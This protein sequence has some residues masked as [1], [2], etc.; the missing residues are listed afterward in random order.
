MTPP[1]QPLPFQPLPTLPARQPAMPNAHPPHPASFPPQAVFSHAGRDATDAFTIWHPGSAWK[2]LERFY[3]GELDGPALEADASEADQALLKDFRAL[4]AQFK[5]EGLFKSN[6]LFYAWKVLSTFALCV[7][8]AA[9]AAMY[10]R[11]MSWAAYALSMCTMGVF[12]QQSGWLA[13]DFLHGQVFESRDLNE[14]FGYVIGNV[15]QGFSVAWW[16]NKH[17]YHHAACNEIE[18]DGTACDPDID[19]IPLLAWDERM[20]SQLDNESALQKWVIKNQAALFFPMLSFAK[21]TWNLSSWADVHLAKE[22]SS[23]HYAVEVA[24][25]A[26]HYL[27]TAALCVYSFGVSPA[28]LGY[29]I[30]ANVV[31]GSLVAFVFVQSHNGKEVH[32]YADVSKNWI[33]MQVETTRN[34]FATPFNDWFSG[35]LNMQIEHHLFPTMPRHSLG[36]TRGRVRELCKKHD[37]LY[38]EHG[39][40]ECTRR[41]L[42]HLDHISRKLD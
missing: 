14:A 29:W 13:H 39:W 7:A 41:V 5:R 17:N 11:D 23:A 1:P 30:G 34:Q 18:Q 16:K 38:E 24:A 21:F 15:W 36:K 8:A 10:G 32:A 27:W 37:L 35:A 19:T 31:G 9:P 12:F 33:R 6:K 22:R 42:S 2:D 3:V 20:L 26:A 40:V 25:L 28:A 4:R